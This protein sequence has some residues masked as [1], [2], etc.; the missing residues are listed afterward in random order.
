[1]GVR[2]LDEVRAFRVERLG[3]GLQRLVFCVE[4]VRFTLWGQV[5]SRHSLVDLAPD[6]RCLCAHWIVGA[7]K[8]VADV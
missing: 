7:R 2:S 3:F 6:T 1:M 8:W 5:P 4:R